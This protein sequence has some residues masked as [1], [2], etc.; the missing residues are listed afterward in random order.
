MYNFLIIFWLRFKPKY[1][2]VLFLMITIGLL[3]SNIFFLV[4][5]VVRGAEVISDVYGENQVKYTK[6]ENTELPG[7]I[8]FFWANSPYF[9]DDHSL[10]FFL[11]HPLNLLGAL[12]RGVQVGHVVD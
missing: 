2:N 9:V 6:T 12:L 5:K 8:Q 7:S 10:L 11:S 3:L 4:L 1:V